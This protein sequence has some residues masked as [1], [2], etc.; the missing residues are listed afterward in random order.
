MSTI[1]ERQQKNT[2]R[3]RTGRIEV[4]LLAEG[5]VVMGKVSLQHGLADEFR[6]ESLENPVI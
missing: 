2:R 6:A 3:T 4:T 1:P 5:P